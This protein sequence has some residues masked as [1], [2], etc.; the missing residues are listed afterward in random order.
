MTPNLTPDAHPFTDDELAEVFAIL[1]NQDSIL[2]LRLV[3]RL[4]GTIEADRRRLEALEELHTTC[5]IS[6]AHRHGVLQND[7]AALANLEEK[8]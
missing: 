3:D 6:E 1:R 8:T 5:K 2:G 4:E 7:V